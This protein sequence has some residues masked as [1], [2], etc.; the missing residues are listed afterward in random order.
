MG[1][2][3]TLVAAA[4]LVTA[5][6]CSGKAVIDA[7]LGSGGGPGSSTTSA[8]T[9]DTGVTASSSGTPAGCDPPFADCNGIADDGCEIDLSNDP[10]N[11]G[12]CAQ[13]CGGAA[14]GGGLCAEPEVVTAGGFNYRWLA[15]GDEHAYFTYNGGLAVGGV[16]KVSKLGGEP[17]LL[18][19]GA[20]IGGLVLANGFLYF[21]QPDVCFDSTC[22]QSG[23]V[24]RVATDGSGAVTLKSLSFVG[25]VAVDDDAVYFG[26]DGATWRK[27]L[28][29]GSEL[30]LTSVGG[31]LLAL[32]GDTLYVAG[33]DSTI[34]AVAKDG[35][36]VFTLYA[37]GD[38][39]DVRAMTVH[40]G[41][42]YWTERGAD[43]GFDSVKRVPVTGGGFEWFA[44][45]EPE[46]QAIGSAGD[47]LY[48]S[49]WSSQIRSARA[50]EVPS[51]VAHNQL[52][53]WAIAADADALYWTNRGD[54]D[55]PGAL[56]KLLR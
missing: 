44:E 16:L 19:T 37:G 48:W 41:Y 23:G 32:E 33:D 27:S 12:V 11:C 13:T 21:T 25:D 54:D 3:T 18:T 4:A 40:D 30:Q 43:S 51:A 31:E 15:L 5:V 45:N 35:S 36:G 20:E 26:G 53:P 17:E 55:T 38:F 22:L 47:R 10:E 42:L 2:L 24:R 1:H 34:V 7:P 46:P 50:S 56:M 9:G 14:C 52:Q 8:G 28:G 39:Y 6:G 49:A 29:D